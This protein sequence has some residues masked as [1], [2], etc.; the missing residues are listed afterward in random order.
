[1]IWVDAIPRHLM[2]FHI[3][4]DNWISFFTIGTDS[5]CKGSI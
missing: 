2:L 4:Y 5:I 3:A 1:M